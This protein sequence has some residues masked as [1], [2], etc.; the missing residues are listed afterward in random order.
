MATSSSTIQDL[1]ASFWNWEDIGS[2][3]FF[4]T[5]F[6]SLLVML[7]LLFGMVT[8]EHG[9]WN[10]EYSGSYT[11]YQI[12]GYL[13]LMVEAVLPMPQIV[14][15]WR[16]KSVQGL[17]LVMVGTWFLGDAYKTFYFLM[18]GL[19]APFILCGA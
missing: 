14:S 5:A 6:N 4:L 15:N 10:Y 1:R 17:S 8:S 18:R 16:K 11:Y 13:A 7:T 19:P 9:K 3:V 2:Y 12:L